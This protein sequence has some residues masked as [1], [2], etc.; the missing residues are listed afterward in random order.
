M[1]LTRSI[2]TKFSA[3]CNGHFVRLVNTKSLASIGAGNFDLRYITRRAFR[4]KPV[5]SIAVTRKAA[6]FMVAETSFLCTIR[7]LRR[8]IYYGAVL[9]NS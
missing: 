3:E 9:I 4:H 1:N 6:D 5:S 2:E 7:T 8:P